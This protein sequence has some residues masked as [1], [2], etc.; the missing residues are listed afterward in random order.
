MLSWT[1]FLLVRHPHVL[2]KLRAEIS[3][4][5]PETLTRAD[6]RKLTYLHNVLNETLRLYPPVP[7]NDRRAEKTIVL[8]TGGGP[9]RTAPVLVPKGT[10]VAWSAYAMHRRPDFYGID[11]EIFRPER[12]D[13]D[14]PVRRDKTN[15]KWGFLPFSGGPRSCLGRKSSSSS[16]PTSSPSLPLTHPF[17]NPK[18]STNADI[19]PLLPFF[20]FLAEDYALTE[21]AYT[22]VRLL[23]RFPTIRLPVGQKVDIVGVEK[24]KMTLVLS[25]TEGCVV[26][27][28]GSEEAR[29]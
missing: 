17:K 12:W 26:D 2:E 19:R 29:K 4:T 14:L 27:F 3:D 16:P 5:D 7:I 11:A 21:A 25:S 10:T 23:H 8:P 28:G 20:V 9:D 18:K 24:Q 1:F 15:A 13:E 22:V 6:L